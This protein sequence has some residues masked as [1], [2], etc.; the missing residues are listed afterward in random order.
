MP[1]LIQFL[2]PGKEPILE[3]PGPKQWSKGRHRR[4]FMVAQGRYRTDC[5]VSSE[6]CDRLV[7]WGEWEAPADVRQIHSDIAS[8]LFIPRMPHYS[9]ECGLQNTDP[10]VFDG[11]FLYGC[12]KQF[13]KNGSYTCLR[14]LDRG[15]VILFG[16]HL[17][18][19]FVLDTLFVV[20]RTSTYFAST[21]PSELASMVAASFVEATLKPLAYN[22]QTSPTACNFELGNNHGKSVSCGPPRDGTQGPTYSLYWGA[23]PDDPVNGMFSF[24]PAK[25]ATEPIEPFERPAIHIDIGEKIIKPGMT[26]GF[27]RV[28]PVKSQYE[29]W[30]LVATKVLDEGL[31]LGTWFQLPF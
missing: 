26:A 31:L 7:F 23:T 30:R 17:R 20:A 19:S 18:G 25:L 11:P 28:Y 10:F 8:A 9:P 29:T 4:S 15:D 5:Q 3:G 24:V 21:G 14:E 13:R 22:C 1:K 16:S 6:A 2:H 12:C 27:R